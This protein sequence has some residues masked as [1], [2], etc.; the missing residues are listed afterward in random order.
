MRFELE[1]DR[2]RAEKR[3]CLFWKEVEPVQF[4]A[5]PRGGAAELREFDQRLMSRN[6]L[7]SNK[8][9]LDLIKKL[10]FNLF[11]LFN[12]SHSSLNFI[13]QLLIS[14]SE[15]R[16]APNQLITDRSAGR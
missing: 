14:V 5:G 9:C 11:N 3:A 2:E 7:T 12:L 6:N 1:T 16:K 13:N 4:G 8:S 15:T 10:M